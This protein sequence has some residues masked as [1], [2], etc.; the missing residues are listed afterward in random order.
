[1]VLALLKKTDV[2]N[3]WRYPVCFCEKCGEEPGYFAY[4]LVVSVFSWRAVYG[5][6]RLAR[7]GCF[8]FVQVV[9]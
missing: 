8:W 5:M 2:R 3:Y 6:R 9:G 7:V 4:Y 1:M